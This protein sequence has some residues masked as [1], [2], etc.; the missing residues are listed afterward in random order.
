MNRSVVMKVNVVAACKHVITDGVTHLFMF[1]QVMDLTC[2][3]TCWVVAAWNRCCATSTPKRRCRFFA[4]WRG[5]CQ[6]CAATRTRLLRL[7][8]CVSACQ[9]LHCLSI[10]PTV[11]FCLTPAGLSHTSQMDPMTRFRQWS[12]LVIDA[13]SMCLL[14][15]RVNMSLL[16]QSLMSRIWVTTSCH[17]CVINCKCAACFCSF[18][19]GFS[20]S[21]W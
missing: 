15:V 13:P 20:N 1:K 2:V 10:I 6:I 18:V 4:T 7:R 14:Y 3:T 21:I 12:M 11:K 19:V 8:L 17:L 16:R 9:R 5:H